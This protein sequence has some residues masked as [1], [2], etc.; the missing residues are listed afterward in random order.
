MDI[1]V[2][3]GGKFTFT[4]GA[5]DLSRGLRMT[6]RNPRNSDFLVTCAGAVGKEGVLQAT[7]ELTRMATATITDSFPFPQIFVFTNMIIVC[8]LKK[9]YEWEAG[10]LVLKYTAAVAESSWSAV[11]FYDYV[12]LSNGRIAVVRDAGSKVYAISSTLPSA[13]AI[14]NYNGQVLIGAPSVTGLG[15]SMML[16]A[17]PIVVTTTQLGS[18][19]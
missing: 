14:C 18:F 19:S 13:T 1:T 15:A 12:Y 2:A 5:K 10:A 16:P 7:D 4:I 17:L 6:K 11:D 3:K 9:I 8:G